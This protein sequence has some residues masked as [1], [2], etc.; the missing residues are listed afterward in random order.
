MAEAAMQQPVPDDVRLKAPSQF[1]LIG[2]GV[3]R[4]DTEAK[5]TGK[6]LFGMDARRPGMKTVLVARPPTFGG[7]V[8]DFDDSATRKMEGVQHVMRVDLDRGATVWPL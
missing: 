3:E 8:V 4:L 5:S 1:K 7:K 2:H 6:Q